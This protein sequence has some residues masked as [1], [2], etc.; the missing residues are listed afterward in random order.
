[1]TKTSSVGL[2]SLA[3]S[4][5]LM[6]SG[7]V[8]DAQTVL[9]Q[10]DPV[11]GVCIGHPKEP[12]CVLPYLFGSGG[13][14]LAPP[15]Q[16]TF[17]HFAHFIGSAQQTLNQ[18]VGTAIA[19]QLAILPII[20]P[21]SGFTYKYDSSAGVFVRS[22]TSFGPIYTERAETI[23][24]GKFTFGTSYQRFRFSNLDGIDLHKVP[25]VF[26]HIPNTGQ[27]DTPEGYEADVIRTTNSLNLNMDQTVFYG[28]VG[29]TDRLDVSV[30]IPLTS[31]RFGASSDASIDRVSGNTFNLLP[32]VPGVPN[33]LPN[34]HSFTNGT[35]QNT[36]AN[37]GSA[38]GIGDITFR[39]KGNL[40]RGENFQ[41]AAIVDI[42]AA[43]GNAREF[44]GSGATG[45]K[46]FVA[47]S[48]GNRFSPHLNLGYQ[49]NGSSILAGNLTGTTVSEATVAGTEQTVIS[50]GSATSSR[51]PSQIIYSLGFDFGATKRLTLS[52]DYLGQALIN[53][54]RVFLSSF[55][56]QPPSTTLAPT[57]K[58]TE[59]LP[60]ITAGKD[61]VGLN[62]GA[63]GFKYNLFGQLLLTGDV[64]FR[65]DNKGLRQD[66]TPLVALSYAFGK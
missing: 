58:A 42:R 47:I 55:T 49:W 65:L 35:L 1:M 33:P 18:G 38:T 14:T 23:G 48:G 44:L 43:S 45:I 20:S 27:G 50:N 26:S 62:S 29:I 56:T 25:A 36:Y 16:G 57:P 13:I 11:V 8:G 53:T 59:T 7:A 37:S 22:T 51:L 66:V 61:T 30:S 21:S 64:L 52:A 9:Q 34:P 46:P 19:T 31:V 6:M 2:R 40:Y 41:V 10:G 60:T 4:L 63:V 39:V 54:P 28:T 12:G 17:T 5:L 3:V 32:P 24:R 15:A